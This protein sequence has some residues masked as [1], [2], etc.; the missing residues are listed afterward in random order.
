MEVQDITWPTDEFPESNFL[1]ILLN[2]HFWE[3][4]HTHA[5]MVPIA[6]VY[7]KCMRTTMA[8]KP[9]YWAAIWRHWSS[10]YPSLIVLRKLVF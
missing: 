7:I 6:L 3:H 10:V 9:M 5:Y 1:L 2:Y 8:T 4:T